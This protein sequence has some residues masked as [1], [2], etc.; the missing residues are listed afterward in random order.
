MAWND[1]YWLDGP[2][3]EMEQ[4]Y[5]Y[6]WWAEEDMKVDWKILEDGS[7]ELSNSNSGLVFAMY[8]AV[9]LTKED[10]KDVANNSDMD[11]ISG[12][13]FPTK[14]CF[15]RDDN[16]MYWSEGTVSE[17]AVVGL[18]GRQERVFC[19]RDSSSSIQTALYESVEEETSSSSSHT[20]VGLVVASIA[21]ASLSFLM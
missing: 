1:H 12:D 13:D 5:I 19:G 14:G 17:M 8:K 16:V 4:N 15:K 3:G 10:C 21:V 6:N 18:P 9:C 11:F 7:L 2:A 20:R